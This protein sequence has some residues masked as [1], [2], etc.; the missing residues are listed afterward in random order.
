MR[1]TEARSSLLAPC[2]AGTLPE[3]DPSSLPSPRDGTVLTRGRETPILTWLGLLRKCPCHPQKN[4]INRRD[5]GPG[6]N[7]TL[8]FYR[9]LIYYKIISMYFCNIT[10]S[11][12]STPYDVLGL[13]FKLKVYI[14]IPILLPYQPHSGRPY[15]CWVLS[16]SISKSTSNLYL[17]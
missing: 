16:I 4:R 14:I 11:H 15:F 2:R 12:S 5:T 9:N 6:T 17:Y 7:N 1:E 8:L 3:F 13:M 10:I